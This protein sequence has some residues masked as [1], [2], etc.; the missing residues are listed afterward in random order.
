MNTIKNFLFIASYLKWHVHQLDINM[1]FL[2]ADLGE[3]AYMK[4]PPGLD[5]PKNMVR[6]LNISIYGLKQAIHQCN[7]KLTNT[8]LHIG[9]SQSKSDYSLFTHK[10]KT[11][12]TDVIM[13]I[14]DLIHAGT[15]LQH[16]ADIKKILDKKSSIRD[17]GYICYFLG[18][19]I[20]RSSKWITLFQQK[21]CMDLLESTGLFGVKPVSTPMDPNHKLNETQEHVLWYPTQYRTII[22]KLLYLTHWH[23]DIM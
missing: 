7:K 5:I 2:H 8:L 17:L 1:M 16:I 14:D 9:F 21:Y 4:C 10:N 13:Y 15:N 11:G 22:R 6:K 19:E 23:P 3:E 18:F 20:A 12:I